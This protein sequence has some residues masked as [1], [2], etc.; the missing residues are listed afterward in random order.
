MVVKKRMTEFAASSTRPFD[1]V[2]REEKWIQC[3]DINVT[4]LN[5]GETEQSFISLLK[6]SEDLSLHNSSNLIFMLLA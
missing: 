4:F 1:L 5:V 6:S 2:E 3:L